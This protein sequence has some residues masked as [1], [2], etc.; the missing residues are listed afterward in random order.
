M[1]D[2]ASGAFDYNTV[3]MRTVKQLTNSGLRS[4]D[5]A[6]GW[7]NR[8]DVAAR[9]AV[10]TGL[11]QLTAKGNDDNA[12]SLGTNT[13][14]VSWH[15]GARPSHQVWQGKALEKKNLRK[16]HGL[17]ADSK[18]GIIKENITFG[19]SLG[20]AGKNYPVKLPDGNHAKFAEGSEIIKIK[21][22]AGKGTDKPIRNAIFLENDYGISADKWQKVRGEG[23]ILFEGQKR[24]AEVHWYE[25]D[26]ERYD[27][28][29]KRWLDES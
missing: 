5:Y 18:G 16:Y 25:A 26:D 12:K 21:V 13:F 17:T 3:L 1:L 4:V 10:M 22:F 6:T 9:R 11:S 27:I 28:K 14:E 29:V 15:S 19:R 24:I 8:V 20:A 23:V 7:S 2:I